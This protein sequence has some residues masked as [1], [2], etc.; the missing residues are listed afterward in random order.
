MVSFRPRPFY[1]QEIPSVGYVGNDNSRVSCTRLHN[2]MQ[3]PE[4]MM[5]VLACIECVEYNFAAV[6]F[7]RILLASKREKCLESGLVSITEQLALGHNI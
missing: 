5:A 7:L 1:G 4:D 2:P 3:Q 6:L